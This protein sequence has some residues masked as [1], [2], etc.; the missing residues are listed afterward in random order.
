MTQLLR[1]RGEG[2]RERGATAT[3]Y[4]VMIAGIVIVL[5]IGTYELGDTL[6]DALVRLGD[7]IDGL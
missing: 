6:R 2:R 5:M 4:A 1:M 7:F 3:E